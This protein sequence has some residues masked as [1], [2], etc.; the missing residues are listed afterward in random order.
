MR[1]NV[2]EF[3][4]A[5]L[6]HTRTS[7]ELEVMLNYN[8]LPGFDVWEPGDHQSLE[9]L[10]L[11]I[12]YK[13][14]QVRITIDVFALVSFALIFLSP[15]R[16]SLWLTRVCSNCSHRYGTMVCP[17]FG[18]RAW[19][20]NWFRWLSL[21]ACFRFTVRFTWSH[22]IR[23]R[24]NSWRNRSSNSSSIRR[25]M[26]HSC[27]CIDYLVTA[28]T[29]AWTA[30]DC[31]V[32]F[33]VFLGA[34]SQRF[35]YLALEVIG[36]PWALEI[37]ADWKLRERGAIPGP[38]EVCIMI[39]VFSNLFRLFPIHRP[40][41][42]D[43]FSFNR[44]NLRRDS[45]VVRKRHSQLFGRP[46]EHNRLHIEL[47]LRHVDRLA[48]HLLVCR[49]SKWTRDVHDWLLSFET[50]AGLFQRDLQN[51]LN[52]YYPREQWDPFDPMLVSE[53][54]FAAGMI[55]SFLKLVHIF[56]INP[57]LGPLQVSLGRMIIDIIKFF[58]IYTLV[59]VAF[60]CGLNQLLWYYADLEKRKCYHLHPDVPDFDN[61]E[62]ACGIWR[63]FAK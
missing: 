7:H 56:S 24:G 43:C 61:Q 26:R 22:R 45:I 48:L 23:R 53:G 62:K 11:A 18:A 60:G 8:P 10:K 1:Q 52:A 15:S 41:S 12:D 17:V 14:K 9:R 35:E 2:L 30:T 19:Q 29:H 50:F 5:L 63:R 34:A 4:T 39:F 21:D 20:A 28:L 32:S 3:A 13:Q 40:L 27:V 37:L 36:T 54:V 38:T 33:A 42:T 46:V 44:L 47:F 51:G 25:A 6:D 55:F 58:F 31:I 59:L 49:S 16:N 57:H